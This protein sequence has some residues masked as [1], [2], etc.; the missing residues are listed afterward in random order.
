M[1]AARSVADDKATV[2]VND[3][4]AREVMRGIVQVFGFSWLRSKKE[5][6]YRYELLQDLRSQL[7]EEELRNRDMAAALLSLDREMQ[8]YRPY[9]DLTLGES[10]VRSVDLFLIEIGDVDLESMLKRWEVRRALD[11]AKQRQ[12]RFIPILLHP[13]EWWRTPFASFQIL[14]RDGRPLSAQLNAADA[15]RD[16]VAEIVAVAE[17]IRAER[18]NPITVAATGAGDY[19]S[20]GEALAHAPAGSV[21][22]VKPGVYTE[23]V[24]MRPGVALR[25]ED[26]ETVI[27]D[28]GGRGWVVRMADET[29]ISGCTIRGSGKQSGVNDC[30]VMVEICNDVVV[31]PDG[32]QTLTEYPYE[33]TP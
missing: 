24:Q 18:T 11:L 7:A 21:I 12:A 4:P 19:R 25:G 15:L 30:G 2:F 32:C 8:A 16:L 29:K 10:T 5:S 20:I 1:R 26:P 33:L 28:G 22:V 27:I 14:P 9:L 13:M 3:R 23:H 31:T 17:E 6:G